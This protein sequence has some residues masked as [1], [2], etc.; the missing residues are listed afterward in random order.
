MLVTGYNRN[1]TQ[2][3]PLMRCRDMR[4]GYIL[5]RLGWNFSWY[6]ICSCYTQV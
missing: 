5:C 2:K 6:S 1:A 3:L 4:T